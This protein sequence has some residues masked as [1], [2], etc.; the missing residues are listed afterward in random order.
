MRISI[1]GLGWYGDPLACKLKELGFKVIGSTRSEEKIQGFKERGIEAITL[2]YPNVPHKELTDID[3]MILNI[4][5]FEQE[6]KWFKSWNLSSQI[7]TIFI[8][9]TSGR[10]NLI[11]Q[12]EWIQS[13]F[14]NWTVLRFSGL[15]GDDR[16]PGNHLSGKK[17]LKGRLWPVNLIHQDDCV[18][19]TV[20]VIEERIQNKIIELTSD[21]HPTREEYYT[22]YCRLKGL[23]LPVFDQTDESTKSIVSNEEMKKY[24]TPSKLRNS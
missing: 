4:P 24:F 7:W 5:P 17:D 21:E 10:K 20:K 12:E 1:L 16:H 22:E 11:E 15:Y 14:N 13:Y 3:I 19:F 2:N 18:A 6:L 9:S 23:P 8:S